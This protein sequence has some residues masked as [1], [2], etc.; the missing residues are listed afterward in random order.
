MSNIENKPTVRQNKQLQQAYDFFNDKLFE[1]ELD[2]LVMVTFSRNS[3]IIGGYFSPDKWVNSEGEKLGEIA[4]NANLF[5]SEGLVYLYNV[6]VHEMVHYW[7]F[8]KGSPS[9]NGYHNQQ[10]IDKAKSIG[11][12]IEGSGQQVGTRFADKGRGAEAMAD[13]P[14][15]FV[16]DW[17]SEELQ[18]DV[19]TGGHVIIQ[20]QPG[21]EPKKSGSRTKYTCARCGAN[22]W[23]KAGLNIACLDCSE[24]LIE[25][26]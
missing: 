5:Q 13:L 11:L 15:D 9:R 14:A 12:E 21:N 8:K 17:F 25:Q 20:Q 1:G 16:F 7:Q 18:V 24:K 6:L 2:N 10:W 19:P 3:N 23:G 26:V 4:I 22:V